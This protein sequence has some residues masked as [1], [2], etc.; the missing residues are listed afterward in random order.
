MNST[1]TAGTMRAIR[2][3]AFGNP[4]SLHLVEDAPPTPGPGEVRISVHAA[5]MNY[6]DLLVVRG[7]YQ[8]LA[9]LPFSPGKEVAGRI[10]AIG[11]GVTALK[12]GM[13][14]LAFPENGGYAEE[15]LAPAVNCYE[16]PDDIGFDFAAANGL[17]CQTAYYALVRRGGFRPGDR[18]LV[19][20]ASG[21]VGGAALALVKALG[22]TALA[23][24]SGPHRAEVARAAGADAIIDLSQPDLAD[25][26][27]AQVEAA[28]GGGRADVIIES[29]GG[30]VFEAALRA[31]DWEGCI[32]V[33]GFAGGPPAVIRSNYLLI[34]N[35][36]AT[37][38]NWADYRD[39][40]PEGVR[41]VQQYLFGL[42]SA[43]RVPAPPIEAYP[44]EEAGEA[45]ERFAR[46]DV[47]GKL[48]LMT[49]AGRGEMTQARSWL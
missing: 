3:A 31:L 4:D 10:S 15:V 30:Q 2:I 43:G 47:T 9:P 21:G 1:P 6:P 44:L 13:R 49:R 46:R 38:L 14:I 42:W 32:V 23:G 48:V 8:V 34:R 41:A 33:V 18:V 27:R 26:L 17:V 25:S 39:Q 7:T 35:L 24:I 16:L 36:T 11:P 22:G 29:V 20:G 37:G 12:L 19:T 28:A 45:L 5:G 40:D